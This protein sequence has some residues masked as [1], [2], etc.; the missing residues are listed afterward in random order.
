MLNFFESIVTWLSTI[1]SII[2]N[3]FTTVIELV[4]MILAMQ[5]AIFPL[6][7]IMPAVI[8]SCILIVIAIC[9]VKLVIGR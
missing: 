3:M 2:L 9:I 8:S 7:S 6:I 4:E 1:A 5:S